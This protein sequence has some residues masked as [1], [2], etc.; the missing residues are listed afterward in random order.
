MFVFCGK[1]KVLSEQ[2]PVEKAV[3][4]LKGQ[5]QTAWSAMALGAAG[6]KNIADYLTQVS[7][8]GTSAADYAKYIL[9]LAGAGENPTDFNGKNFVEGLRSHYEEGTNQFGDANYISDDIWAILALGSL[10]KEYLPQ[11][12]NSKQFILD[13]QN[14]DGGWSFGLKGS[15]SSADMTAAAIMALIESGIKTTDSVIANAKNYLKSIQKS[16]GGFPGWTGDSSASSDAWVI[17]AIYKLGENPTTWVEGGKNP[18]EHLKSL[19]DSEKGFFYDT[20]EG[21]GEDDFVVARTSYA[22]IALSGKTYPIFSSYNSHRL[23]IEGTDATICDRDINGATPLDLVIEAAILCTFDYSLQ[24]YEDYD[25]LLLTEINSE[26]NWEYKVENILP[27]IGA[28]NYYLEP[29]DKVLWYGVANLWGNWFSTKIELTKDE[30]QALVQTY[31]YKSQS[32]SWQEPTFSLA[33]RV[34]DDQMT[35]DNSGKLELN[36]VVF[37][38]GLYPVFVEQQIVEDTG[39]IRSKKVNLAIG[40]PPPT[41]QVNLKVDIELVEVPDKGKQESISFSVSPDLLDFGK[42]KPGATAEKQISINNGEAAIYLE[43]EVTGHSVFRDNLTLDDNTW[44]QFL[45]ELEAEQ[46]EDFKVGLTIPSNY[47]DGLGNQTGSLTFW[48]VK[49]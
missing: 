43:T 13:N 3:N 40:Q 20:Q 25:S 14:N 28:D 5:P 37:A 29:E 1:Q 41:H 39:Y 34:G 49:K 8:S 47:S 27:M 45:A 32:Q 19:Q 31:Y 15:P 16:D 33:V 26:A 36:T 35:T 9:A 46:S 11:V 12:Q 21:A 42:L 6:E 44:Q 2:T 10:G 17:S 18:I 7:F 22:V 4:Y 23:R 30:N 48:A 38:D 24:Y